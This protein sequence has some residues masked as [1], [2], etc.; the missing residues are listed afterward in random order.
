MTLYYKVAQR[1]AGQYDIGY[2][3]QCREIMSLWLRQGMLPNEYYDLGVRDNPYDYVGLRE[4]K[5]IWD[6]HNTLLPSIRPLFHDKHEMT[7]FFT[8]HGLPT[9]Y[10]IPV[11]NDY[12]SFRRYLPIFAK[13]RDGYGGKGAFIIEKYL[14]YDLYQTTRG[15]LTSQEIYTIKVKERMVFQS[16]LQPHEDIVDW[17]GSTTV[18]ALRLIT[19]CPA[20]D[21]AQVVL[22]WLKFPQSN[23]VV[24]NLSLPG[25]YG[26][27]LSND[28]HIQHMLSIDEHFIPFTRHPVTGKDLK[29]KVVPYYQEAVRLAEKAANIV[30]RATDANITLIGFD[31]A[32]TND[33]PVIME[34]NARPGFSRI[35]NLYGPIVREKLHYK[36][37]PFL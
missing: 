25:N 32:L 7:R 12:Y 19:D 2:L 23:G 22:K 8:E 28:G 1:L 15:K 4:S 17:T 9:T 16:V 13:R 5:R 14:S 26:V 18:G 36:E 3:R 11:F 33:G 30:F 20:Q 10:E 24:D 31:I 34:M 27:A 21:M 37:W 6:R 29:G 35:Q